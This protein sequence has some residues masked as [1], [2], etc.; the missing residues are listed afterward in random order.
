MSNWAKGVLAESLESVSKAR[1]SRL[2]LVN[3]AY[4]SQMDSHTRRLE[5]KRVYDKFYHVNG[6][7]SHAGNNAAANIKHRADDTEI[8]LYMSHQTVKR[9]L[10]YRIA[11]AGGV[12]KVS[13][14]SD[15]P[16]RTRVARTKV[17]STESE[18][19]KKCTDLF[20]IA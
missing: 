19:P 10:L 17:I 14:P 7:I 3:A 15:R 20:R 13:N 5:G 12:S 4:T 8:S 11:A 6:D 18:V 1:R 9:I 16:S 2:R